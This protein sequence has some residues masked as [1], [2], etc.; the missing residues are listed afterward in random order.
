MNM[1]TQSPYLQLITRLGNTRHP[2]G[3]KLSEELLKKI[4]I[5]KSFRVLD[6]GCGAGHTSAFVAESFG[7]NV[8]GVD[9]SEDALAQARALYGKEPFFEQLNFIPSSLSYLPFSD[10]YFDIVLCESVLLFVKDK[11]QALDEI[12]RVL[13]PGGHLI[14]NELCL[15][16]NKGRK[17]LKAYFARPEL[18]AFLVTTDTYVDYFPSGLWELLL[19]DERAFSLSEQ[20]VSDISQ[21]GNQKSF[22]Q[23]LE[24]AYQIINDDKMRKDIWHLTKFFFHMPPKALSQLISLRLLLQKKLQIDEEILQG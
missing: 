16:Q 4:D 17:M 10:G 23:L 24:F 7:C 2:G 1:T 12:T 14:I 19:Q 18:G 20:I 5:K 8:V 6:V 22:F 21:F 3:L 11:K 13:K 9:I 15:T